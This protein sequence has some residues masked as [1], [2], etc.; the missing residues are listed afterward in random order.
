MV[1]I[2]LNSCNSSVCFFV[3]S[4]VIVMFSTALLSKKVKPLILR[5]PEQVLARSVGLM[6]WFKSEIVF[7]PF[8]GWKKTSK[9]KPPIIGCEG[10]KTSHM[11]SESNQGR[12]GE[13]RTSYHGTTSSPVFLNVFHLKQTSMT[14]F[15]RRDIAP[16][17][18]I[19]LHIK[20]SVCCSVKFR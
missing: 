10:W 1:W 19:T 8:W 14:A 12:S 13:R 11:W 4:W 9:G 18:L 7:K 15:V 6:R 20:S 5:H 17:T 3:R 2:F 16:I